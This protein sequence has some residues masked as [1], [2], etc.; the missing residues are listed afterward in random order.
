MIVEIKLDKR[1]KDFSDVQTAIRYNDDL[2]GEKGYFTCDL[3]DLQDLTDCEYSELAEIETSLNDNIFRTPR[4]VK[5]GRSGYSFFV[6]ESPL[7]PVE[8]K[9]RAFTLREFLERYKVGDSFL[10]RTKESPIKAE[11]CV[12]FTEHSTEFYN[13]G[14]VDDESVCLGIRNYC[15]QS[16]FDCYELYNGK[17]WQPFGIE[18]DF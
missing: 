7:R 3:V 2:I 10:I 13:D 18:D 1:I 5:I 4:D 6:P 8:K 9:Y 15:F 12:L 16:L 14:R 17:D 11:R